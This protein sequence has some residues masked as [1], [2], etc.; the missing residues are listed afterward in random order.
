MSFMS[1]A[2][3][4]MVKTQAKWLRQ[5]FIRN[6]SPLGNK[7]K[8]CM[9]SRVTQSNMEASSIGGG[10]LSKRYCVGLRF[11]VWCALI[12]SVS[13]EWA[14]RYAHPRVC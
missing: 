11:T 6:S 4:L 1:I 12:A 10:K 7:H 2:K 14:C 9:R 3:P 5:K 13:G 8:V